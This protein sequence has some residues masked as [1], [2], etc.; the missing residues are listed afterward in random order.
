MPDAREAWRIVFYVAA[1]VSAFGGV[2]V[3][4]TLK[5]DVQDWARM[6]EDFY[7]TEDKKGKRNPSMTTTEN[8]DSTEGFF[9]TGQV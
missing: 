7:E 4:A 6:D 5:T 9:K 2:A 8:D 3:L 1:A